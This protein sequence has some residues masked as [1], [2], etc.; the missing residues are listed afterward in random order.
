MPILLCPNITLPCL[1][2][3]L[4]VFLYLLEEQTSAWW[5]W[6]LGR[7]LSG[8]RQSLPKVQVPSDLIQ[9][10]DPLVLLEPCSLVSRCLSVQLCLR[11]MH[12]IQFLCNVAVADS[13]FSSSFLQSS[14]LAA[15]MHKRISFDDGGVSTLLCTIY[16]FMACR[17]GFQQWG[18]PI[19]CPF[20]N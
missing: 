3:S 7:P 2:S 8:M 5:H 4:P 6:Q 16:G 11:T 12:G 10:A 14:F 18:I 1:R 20:H 9:L 13:K 17:P 15:M 19:L